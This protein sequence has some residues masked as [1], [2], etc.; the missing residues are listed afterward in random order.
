MQA[1]CGGSPVF[2]G[3]GSR[4]KIT[5]R[6]W[7]TKLS[8]SFTCFFLSKKKGVC[9]FNGSNPFLSKMVE[10]DLMEGQI[11]IRSVSGSGS[12][13]LLCRKQRQ[14]CHHTATW[15]ESS[16]SNLIRFFFLLFFYP[17]LIAV[18]YIY[19]HEGYFSVEI[20]SKIYSICNTKEKSIFNYIKILM[21]LFQPNHFITFLFNK[22]VHMPIKK[23]ERRLIFWHL[24]LFAK[25]R[26]R[27][28][29]VCSFVI[30]YAN[31]FLLYLLLLIIESNREGG[32]EGH[33]TPLS[34]CNT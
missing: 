30:W 18:V 23:K 3:V 12:V 34:T 1:I 5:S 11:R 21:N 33:Y 24:Q 16:N 7:V 15:R 4:C 10:P 2:G 31:N 13:T 14:I 6:F 29:L 9:N 17:S 19:I 26:E 25:K 32:V 28:C 22:S 27:K 8:L 20:K